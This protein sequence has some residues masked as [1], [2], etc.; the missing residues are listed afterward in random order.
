MSKIL[1]QCGQ[2]QLSLLDNIILGEEFFKRSYHKN[3]N[4]FNVDG[5]MGIR[6]EYAILLAEAID[7]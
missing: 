4:K 7:G 2:V 3:K 1:V 6:D 5:R